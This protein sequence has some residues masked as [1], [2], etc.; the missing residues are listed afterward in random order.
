[1]NYLD[2]I[3]GRD[4]ITANYAPGSVE[5]VTQHDG[6]VLKLRKLEADYDPT[7]KLRAMTYLQEHQAAGEIVTGLL[8]LNPEPESLHERLHTVAV[9]L[10]ALSTQELCPGS[11]A[12]EDVNAALR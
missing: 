2:V 3:E 7:D 8:Y 10:N 6:S 1:V 11:A 4:P 12:L 5:I 9:P